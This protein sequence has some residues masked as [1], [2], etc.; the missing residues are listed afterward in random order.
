M[1]TQESI[2]EFY[3]ANACCSTCDENLLMLTGHILGKV[4]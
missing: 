4:M 1:I 3:H 2:D